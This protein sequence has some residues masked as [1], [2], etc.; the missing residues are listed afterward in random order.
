MTKLVHIERHSCGQTYWRD[1]TGWGVT[2]ILQERDIQ[3]RKGDEG[4][5]TRHCQ[6][7]SKQE[8][9]CKNDC[10]VLI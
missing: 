5:N 2:D 4:L 1:I 6:H 9:E 8:S 7:R 10:I 3:E